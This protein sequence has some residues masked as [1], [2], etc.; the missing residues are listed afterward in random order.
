[1]DRAS[2]CARLNI[3]FAL[4]ILATGKI[5]AQCGSLAGLALGLAADGVRVLGHS[6]WLAWSRAVVGPLMIGASRAGAQASLY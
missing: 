2:Y 4:L 3:L 6:D 1:M 5:G